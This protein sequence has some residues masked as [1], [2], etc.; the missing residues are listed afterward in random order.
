MT[1][2]KMTTRANL[3]NDQQTEQANGS[4]SSPSQRSQR[5]SRRNSITKESGRS[6]RNSNSDASGRASEGSGGK[7]RSSMDVVESAI[8][9][10]PEKYACP[11]T[12][13]LT[14]QSPTPRA[15]HIYIDHRPQPATAVVLTICAHCRYREVQ[16]GRWVDL[17][18]ENGKS[19]T[20]L[21]PEVSRSGAAI[22]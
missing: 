9:V 8:R 16:G 1:D 17:V 14:C 6:K 13:Y 20:V 22:R 12:F 7:R 11:S 5:T 18:L 19:K 15:P 3:M 2:A 10:A 4:E 21:I